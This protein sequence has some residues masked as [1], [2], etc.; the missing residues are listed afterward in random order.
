M[1]FC[2]CPWHYIV[3][4]Y[5][6]SYR[7]TADLT[8]TPVA[9]STCSSLQFMLCKLQNLALLMITMLEHFVAMPTLWQLPQTHCSYNAYYANFFCTMMSSWTNLGPAELSQTEF[10]LLLASTNMPKKGNIWGSCT[11]TLSR[12][13]CC[14]Q[15]TV[16]CFFSVVE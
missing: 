16:V 2:L 8:L 11:I 6:F 14:F 13:N 9:S 5:I 10:Q 15:N 4:A 1:K 3:T 12:F 7:A